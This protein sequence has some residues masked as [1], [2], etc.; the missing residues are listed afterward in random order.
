MGNDEG[1]DLEVDDVEKKSGFEGTLDTG[2]RGRM[3]YLPAPGKLGTYEFT[4]KACVDGWS[5]VD[6]DEAT[7][8]IEVK[9]N[10][11]K[12]DAPPT[13]GALDNLAV[14]PGAIL[15]GSVFTGAQ[16]DTRYSLV[17][18]DYVP[19]SGFTGTLNGGPDGIF[20]YGNAPVGANMF[21]CKI[22]YKEWMDLCSTATVTVTT[23]VD[24]VAVEG[25]I[26]LVPGSNLRDDGVTTGLP[27]LED[28][29]DGT[30]QSPA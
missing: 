16:F 30:H 15:Q 26:F 13:P 28:I 2:N 22:C 7:V 29:G 3:D 24:A 9:E 11:N 23:A 1:D 12:P 6:C 19:S 20:T 10:P 5:C 21:T 4:Y 25:T 18:M 17:A 8:K 27:A 14:S